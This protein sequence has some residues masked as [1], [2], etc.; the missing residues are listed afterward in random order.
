MLGC[1]ITLADLELTL[2]RLDDAQRTFERALELADARGPGLR[3]TADMLVGL[4]RVAWERNDLAAAADLLRRAD[5]LGE[6]AELAAEPLPLAGRRWPGSARR[7]ATSA[8]ALQLLEEAERVYVGDYS[9]NVQPV[10][11][12]RAR[13]LAARGDVAGALAWAQRARACPPTTSC[14]TCASTST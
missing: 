3:G 1:T 5:E 12:T 11:A 4:S 9:P 6:S 7:R 2:G 13:V 8:A 10:P 14:P